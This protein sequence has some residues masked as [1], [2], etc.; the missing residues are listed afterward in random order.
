MHVDL[1]RR[2]SGRSG[3]GCSRRGGAGGPQGITRARTRSGW[4]R[5]MTEKVSIGG[6]CKK[7]CRMREAVPSVCDNNLRRQAAT[8]SLHIIV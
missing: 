7:V 6:I 4:T 1:L 5:D 3:S 2:I 8:E